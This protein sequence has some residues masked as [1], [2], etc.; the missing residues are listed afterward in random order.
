MWHARGGTDSGCE[1]GLVL[2]LAEDGAHYGAV[3]A[4]QAGE[5]AGL[6]LH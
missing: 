4:T 6:A 1:V 2:R 3:A 5:E